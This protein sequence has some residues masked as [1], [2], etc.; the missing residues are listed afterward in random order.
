MKNILIQKHNSKLFRN[1]S[2]MKFTNATFFPIDISGNL[3]AAHYSQKFDAIIF[4]ESAIT[5]EIKQ[6]IEEFSNQIKIIVYRDAYISKNGSIIRRSKNKNIFQNDITG[7]L[8]AAMDKNITIL[9]T[10]EY[11]YN[12]E[13]YSDIVQKSE[14]T[15]QIISFMDEIEKCPLDLERHLYPSGKK[16]IKLFNNPKIKSVN[17]LGVLTEQDRKD[18]LLESKHYLS[19]DS[20]YELEARMCGCNIL[21]LSKLDKIDSTVDDKPF[22]AITYRQFIEPIL[23]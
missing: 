2:L 5:A 23:L 6:Y 10:P 16:R 14:K 15:E 9:V 8:L 18:I 20:S 3:Y 1:L 7:N 13:I 21:T 11:I 17:N 19:I 12:D 4:A 22:P